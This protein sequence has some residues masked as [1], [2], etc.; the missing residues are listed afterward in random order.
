METAKVRVGL[1]GIGAI[2]RTHFGCYKNTPDAE[3]VA[4]CD[5]DSRKLEGDWSPQGFNLG[6]QDA[7][8]EDLSAFRTYN[9]WKAI[10]ADPEIDMIDVCLPIALHAEVATA[11]LKAGKH[12]LCEKPMARTSAQCGEM[13]AAARESGKQLMIAHCLRYWPHYVE[14]QKVIAGGEYGKP[15]YAR[16]HR[17]SGTPKWSYQDWLRT[18][19]ESGGSLLDMHVHDVDAALWYFGKPDTIEANGI[20]AK[21]LPTAVDAVWSYPDGL[22]VY[23]HNAWDENETP[24]RY[25]FSIAMETGTI[26]FDSSASDAKLRIYTAGNEPKVIELDSSS[27]Y[28]NEIDDFTSCIRSGKTADRITL[29][30]GRA[31]VEAV[32]EET[33]QLYVK[34]GRA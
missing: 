2:G 15:L 3:L 14:T 22:R 32:E 8:R 7:R 6:A 33:R 34:H 13:E 17:A 25:A 28:Q 9:D 4:L 21:D 1:I 11:A 29:A 27:A 5:V 20:F 12:V 19:S 31:A 26:A 10:I 16:F 18:A 24:F 23:L 30:D